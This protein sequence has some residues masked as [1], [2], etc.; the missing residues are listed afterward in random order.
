MAH[1]VWLK[2]DL[3]IDDHEALATAVARGPVVVLYVYEPEYY[4]MAEF[5]PSHHVFIDESLAE[6]ERALARRGGHITYRVGAMPD[7]LEALRGEI[8]IESLRSHEETGNAITY[9]RD[10]RVGDWC[11]ARGIVWHEYAQ[12]GVVRVLRSRDGWAKRWERRMLRPLVEAPS[13]VAGVEIAH[14]SRRS[15]ADLGL[16]ASTKNEALPGG[17]SSAEALLATFLTDRGVDYRKAMSSPVTAFDAC[18]RLSPYLA[19]GAISMKRVYQATVARTAEVRALKSEGVAVDSR[20]LGAMSSFSGRLHWHCH[21]MQKLEDQPSLEFEN[22]ARAYDGLRENAFDTDRFEAWRAGATGYPM[23]DACM[24]ALHRCGWIN[25]RMRA[26]LMS[27]ASYHLWLHWRPTAVYLGS[28]FLDFEAGIHYPQSQMQ[29]GTTGINTLRIYSPTKQVI[30]NDPTGVFI[31]RYVPELARVPAEFIA[32]PHLMPPLVAA[33]IG[34]RIGIDYPLPI[35]DHKLA[36]TRAKELLYAIR[37]GDAARTEA[38]AVVKKHGS[39]K[40]APPRQRGA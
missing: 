3:R 12:T 6:L 16:A 29:S 30:D 4:A 9:A 26:M 28:Q 10:K 34:F 37:R 36:T 5:D 21:F 27:F 24:R 1:L 2:R 23:V 8:D 35:V 31:R 7:V 20:W 32:E 39:R 18:S 22:Q 25:F 14:E 19:Y 33:S 15:L 40:P 13:R 38:R 17:S 11:R